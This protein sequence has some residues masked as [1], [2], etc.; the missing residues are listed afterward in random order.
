MGPDEKTGLLES[1]RR[2]GPLP[3]S[4]RGL[5]VAPQLPPGP[6][7][8]EWQAATIDRW[9][10][11]FG[12]PD[13]WTVV[14]VG[15]G[16]GCQARDVLGLGPECLTALRYVLVEGDPAQRQR[17]ESYLPIESPALLFGPAGEEDPDDGTGIDG[18]A[19]PVPGVGPLVTSLAE[20]PVVDGPAAVIAIGW[21]SRLPSDV[22]EW[23]GGGWW[24][25]RLAAD[26][27]GIR[28]ITV[29]LDE[30]RADAAEGL[31]G[32]GVGKSVR[33]DGVR[34]ARLAPACKW[35]AE[36]L[37]VAESGRLAIVDRWTGVTCVLVPGEAPPLALDQL[38]AVRP[39][40]EPAPT[41]LFPGLSVVTWRLG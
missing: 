18:S 35:V 24:E 30:E 31:A 23:N 37:R 11:D 21:V 20:L 17:Q 8:A 2:L 5:H 3:Y 13:P 7:L 41:E 40:L 33:V 27:A 39:A 22:L 38:G 26:G 34:V 6:A 4:A 10:I 9:W 16:D 15:A 14:H 29:P 36:A 1:A 25:V 12:R 28:E 32:A 19:R